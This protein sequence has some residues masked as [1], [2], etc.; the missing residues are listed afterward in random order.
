[1]ICEVEQTEL[2]ESDSWENKGPER[3]SDSSRSANQ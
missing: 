2:F 1:M 3:L